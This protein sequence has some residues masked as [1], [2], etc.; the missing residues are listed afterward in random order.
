MIIT[1]AMIINHVAGAPILTNKVRQITSPTPTTT[2]TTLTAT[3]EA[4]RH[5]DDTG[6]FGLKISM[7]FLVIIVGGAL[8]GALFY[9]CFF[10]GFKKEITRPTHNTSNSYKLRDVG[11]RDGGGAGRHWPQPSIPKQA[12]AGPTSASPYQLPP[13]R[14]PSVY[15]AAPR[16]PIDWTQYE[17]EVD[18]A[19]NERLARSGGA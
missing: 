8:L 13:G 17:R 19:R 5:I 1:V 14:F 7:A 2:P 11:S 16:S 18:A 3:N 12:T 10:G 15:R 6:K 4:N 9:G